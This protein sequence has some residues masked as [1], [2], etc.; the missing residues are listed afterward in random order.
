MACHVLVYSN[1]LEIQQTSSNRLLCETVPIL[2]LPLRY[3]V[4]LLDVLLLFSEAS[5]LPDFI[6]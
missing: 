2:S 1:F 5:L 4:L 6:E 3:A